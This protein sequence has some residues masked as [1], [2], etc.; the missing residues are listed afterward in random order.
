[1]ARLATDFFG[2][3]VA[4]SLFYLGP[5]KVRRE[6]VGFIEDNEV[7][8]VR[9]ELFLEGFVPRYLIEPSDDLVVIFEWIPGRRACF[10]FSGINMKLQAEF[11]K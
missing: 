9:T 4:S 10:E 6:F 2:K 3:A 8:G 11:L 5:K 1:M 7:P